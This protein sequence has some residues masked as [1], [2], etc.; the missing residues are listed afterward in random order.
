MKHAYRSIPHNRNRQSPIPIAV[1]LA[2][3]QLLKF[4]NF[5]AEYHQCASSIVVKEAEFGG[6]VAGVF[7]ILQR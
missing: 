7:M 1:K 4:R 5:I 3:S 6:R 2:Y